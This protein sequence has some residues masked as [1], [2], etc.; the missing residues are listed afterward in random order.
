M[1]NQ[2]WLNHSQQLSTNMKSTQHKDDE[3]LLL[4]KSRA[5]WSSMSNRQQ[6]DRG[7]LLH[8]DDLASQL[9]A[10]SGRDVREEVQDPCLI[11]STPRVSPF[12]VTSAA[13]HMELTKSRGDS[14]RR[15]SCSMSPPNIRF[16]DAQSGKADTSNDLI[17]ESVNSEEKDDPGSSEASRAAGSGSGS[18]MD[19]SN[20][21]FKTEICRNYKEKGSCLYGADCQFAHGTQEMRQTGRQN[22]YKT[23]RCQKYWIAGYCA[24]G[25][26]CNF[27]HCDS[28]VD[29]NNLADSHAIMM[30][31]PT[32]NLNGTCRTGGAGAVIVPPLAQL[33]RPMYGSGRL[34]HFQATDGRIVWVDTRTGTILG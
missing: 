1:I 19:E 21:R 20:P 32:T 17:K 14:S 2:H 15:R 33:T 6:H 26:R 23:K 30:T 22:K 3:Q 16:G 34:C 5:H 10:I 8:V 25:P 24:Y 7:M 13:G 28:S 12:E 4:P 29:D 11:T 9:L 31:S 27:V 18:S